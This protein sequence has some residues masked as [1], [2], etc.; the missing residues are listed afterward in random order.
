LQIWRPSLHPAAAEHPKQLSVTATV[1]QKQQQKLHRR[2]ANSCPFLHRGQTNLQP[3]RRAC[4]TARLQ[5]HLILMQLLCQLP[6]QHCRTWLLVMQSLLLPKRDVSV[7]KQ[8]WHCSL[9]LTCFFSM[10]YAQHQA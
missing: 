4:S 2:H 5:Q 7:L 3:Q 6:Q 1:D 9:F 8:D 10:S